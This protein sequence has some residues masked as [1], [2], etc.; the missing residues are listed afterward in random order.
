MP[1]SPKKM[2]IQ[3]IRATASGPPLDYSFLGL[4]SVAELV[5]HEHWQREQDN[6]TT[7][8]ATL[9]AVKGAQPIAIEQD[10]DPRQEE[11]KPLP[12][13]QLAP[14]KSAPALMTT[15]T[16]TT[17]VRLSNNKL[18]TIKDL[19]A[20]IDDITSDVSKIK[21]VDLSFNQLTSI[22]EALLQCPQL[23]TLNLHS[24]S[25][26]KLKDIKLLRHFRQLKSLTLHGNPVEDHKHYRNYVLTLVPSLR[27]I[28]FS[29]VT[30]QD[31]RNAETWKAVYRQ[32]LSKKRQ[33]EN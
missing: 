20:A 21:W 4:S 11:D 17:A 1:G 22:E 24:N 18:T 6:Y 3:Q 26:E 12:S 9:P 13:P 28:D 2:T 10:Q 30:K 31:R 25:I 7:H 27:S 14:S 29:S 15:T 32:K 16:T 33:S 8:T 19:D 5:E 23:T